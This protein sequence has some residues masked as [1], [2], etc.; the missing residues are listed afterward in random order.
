MVSFFKLLILLLNSSGLYRSFISRDR[1]GKFS[2]G[3]FAQ[4]RKVCRKAALL[5]TAGCHN[6]WNSWVL[7]VGVARSAARLLAPGVTEQG[8]SRERWDRGRRSRPFPLPGCPAAPPPPPRAGRAALPPGKSGRNAKAPLCWSEL[9]SFTQQPSYIQE[10]TPYWE[11]SPSF[12][13]SRDL[14][15]MHGL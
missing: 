6:S 8:R 9:C 7:G 11:M 1:N 15:R 2:P 3:T 4:P 13:S 5:P 12:T 10:L 14:F